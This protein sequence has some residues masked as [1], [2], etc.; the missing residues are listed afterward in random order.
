MQAT[1]LLPAVLLG[2]TLATE[3]AA[4]EL[5]LEVGDAISLEAEEV[6]LREVLV[7]ISE[8]APLTLVERGAAPEGPVSLTVEANTWQGFFRKLLGRESHLL[9]L[10]ADTGA[11]RQL[12]VR[13]D[14]VR[15]L[16]A[17]MPA[18]GGAPRPVWSGAR[19]AW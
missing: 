4:G 15:E 7:E 12:V 9:T 17:T 19:S 1:T 3:A 6:T 11:P 14:A 18:G 8:A 13:W 5:K 2:L 16:Q 10:D